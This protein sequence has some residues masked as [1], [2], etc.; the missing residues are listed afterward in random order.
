MITGKTIGELNLL[1]QPTP[2]TLIPVELNGDTYHIAYSSITNISSTSI[3]YLGKNIDCLNITSGMNMTQVIE[4][5]GNKFC[6]EPPIVTCG[7]IILKTN[8][9]GECQDP[10]Q[11]IFNQSILSWCEEQPPVVPCTSNV[12]SLDYLF[13]DV[14]NT[15]ENQQLV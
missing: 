10:L 7:N 4:S 11:Y 8:P 1:G 3:I 12:N 14:I 2:N 5:I 15:W 6:S 9:I 13:Q